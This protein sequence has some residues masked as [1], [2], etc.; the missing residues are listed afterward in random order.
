MTSSLPLPEPSPAPLQ[1]WGL[2]A[3]GAGLFAFIPLVLYLFV[4]HPEPLGLSLGGGV[5]LMLG[6]RFLARPYMERVRPVRCLWCGRIPP[7]AGAGGAG[8][9]FEVVAGGGALA[10]RACP[11]HALPAA[12]FV[13][14]LDAWRWPLRLGIFVPLVLLLAALAGTAAGLAVPLGAATDLF[15]LAIGL[16][17]NLA[18]F[19]YLAQPPRSRPRVPF[20]A[21]NFW[22]LGIRPLLWILRLVGLWWIVAGLGGLSAGGG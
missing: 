13:S 2:L 21:H 19:G 14:F 5:A 17:V 9:S 15:R 1:R 20:P 16:T 4:G 11:G 22:L 8:E 6:H 10:A 7:R 12:R 18:A 3:T